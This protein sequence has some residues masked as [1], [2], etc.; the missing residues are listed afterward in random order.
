MKLPEALQTL[1]RQSKVVNPK[2]R[3]DITPQSPSPPFH[4]SLPGVRWL[5]ICEQPQ[6]GKAR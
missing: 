2:S 1:G 6:D 5:S 4:D 3:I